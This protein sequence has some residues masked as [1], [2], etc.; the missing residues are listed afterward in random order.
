MP[1]RE[2]LTS[3]TSEQWR[4]YFHKNAANLLDI[5]WGR[6]VILSE[7]ERADI[8]SSMQEFQLGES[9][10][11]KHFQGLAKEYS[12]L[13]GDNNYIYALR[14]FISEEHRHARDLG[15]VMDLAG[16]ARSGHT[17]PDA[18]FRWL[19][20]RA[21]LELSI[22]VLVTAEIIAKVYYIALRDATTSS[23]LRRLCEQILS[24]EV[25]HV[26]FQCERL[27]IIRARRSRAA[28]W[29]KGAMQCWFFG[30][31][32]WVVWWK[33]RHALRAGGFSY[34]TFRRA[35]RREMWE[36]VALMN[37]RNYGSGPVADARLAVAARAAVAG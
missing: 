22:G 13:T 6:G 18:V 12:Q 30:G 9:S 27:A 23:V 19:R 11:G 24:D 16:I 7:S 28:V 3:M 1:Q 14:L 17:W 8:A 36:A 10:E 26:R 4:D 34:R 31:T 35:A 15:R 5:P 25:Q 29:L 33:H 20:H 2:P 37:P 21:G 32:C